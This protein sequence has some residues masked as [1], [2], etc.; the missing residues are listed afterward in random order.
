MQKL[1][2]KIIQNIKDYFKFLGFKWKYYIILYYLILIFFIFSSKTMKLKISSSFEE[3]IINYASVESQY[4]LL[5]QF[6]YSLKFFDMIDLQETCFELIQ[7][8]IC[9]EEG[10]KRILYYYYFNYFNR[11]L[12]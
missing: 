10:H 5:T 12:H 3:N 11:C 7:R 9:S 6:F 2:S 1:W 4:T 8:D